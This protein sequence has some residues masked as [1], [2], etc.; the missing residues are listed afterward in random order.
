MERLE[1]LVAQRRRR[2]RR[3]RRLVRAAVHRPR[4][5]QA[6]QR[7]ARPP[8]RRPRAADRGRA[9]DRRAAGERRRRPLR[10]RRVPGAAARRLA[11]RG[12][13]GGDAQADGARSRWRST[14]K[15]GRSSV[16]PSI[17]IALLP[18]GRHDAGRA[19][20]PRRRGD[21]RGQ[22]ARPGHRG[23]STM[24]SLAD[25]AY[26]SLVMEGELA[27]AIARD[28]FVLHFQPQVL[29]RQRRHRRRR[30][31]DPLAASRARTARARRVHPAGRA[32]PA[33]AADR[34]LGAAHGGARAPASWQR[35][36]LAGA[37]VGVNLTSL[38]FEAPGFV[39]HV[40]AV[41]REE[42]LPGP[43]LELEL[44]ER[45]VTTDLHQHRRHARPA[46]GAR[47]AHLARRLRHRLHLARR[48][49]RRCRSTR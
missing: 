33:D 19:D 14:P 15:A 31:A 17:G 43:L 25:A 3:R 10:R 30:G 28:E 18:A 39:E 20:P 32:A 24:P 8:G 45:M 6:R 49:S 36:A 44:T 12:H 26:A 16:S 23:A 11:A 40:A 21:A 48:S 46:E 34:P 37:I 4:P 13:R 27:Q 2:A 42:G 47:R 9:P 5:L 41:L 35:G 1:H 7:L 38:Q 22:A 29:R